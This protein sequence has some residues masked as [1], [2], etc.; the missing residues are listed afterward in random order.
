MLQAFRTG[1]PLLKP[2][3]KAILEVTENETIQNI[4]KRYFGEGYISQYQD[5]DISGTGSSLT[6]YSFAGLF[7]VTAFLTLLAVVCSEC[8][9]AISRYRNQNIASISKV[10]SIEATRGISPESNQQDLKEVVILGQEAES[11]EQQVLQE[12]TLN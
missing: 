3:S 9:F 7:T 4:E 2:I 1:S 11:N 12:S 6:S 10:H 5:K 8:S